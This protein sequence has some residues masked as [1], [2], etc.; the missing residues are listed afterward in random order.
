MMERTTGQRDE[1]ARREAFGLAGKCVWIFLVCNVTVLVS[2]V[3]L[4]FLGQGASTFMWARSAIL[5]VASPFLLWLARRAAAGS[6]AAVGRLRVVS[7]VL[8]VAVVVVDFLPGVAPAWYGVI[9]GIGA[10]ALIPAAVIAWRGGRH[11]TTAQD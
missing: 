2:V 10:L 5:A 3:V 7:T 9:Q 6:R 1:V 11:P 8:P 4:T